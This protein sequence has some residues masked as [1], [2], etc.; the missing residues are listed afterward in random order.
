MKAVIMLL[1]LNSSATEKRDSTGLQNAGSSGHETIRKDRNPAMNPSLIIS[2][3]NTIDTTK[4][5]NNTST[6]PSTLQ[7]TGSNS[8]PQTGRRSQRHIEPV[9]VADVVTLL[10]AMLAIALVLHRE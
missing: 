8:T 5:H 7:P 4:Q 10:H 1:P 2:E 3:K 9:R 6:C